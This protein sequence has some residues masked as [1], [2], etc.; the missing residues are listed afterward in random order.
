M[1]MQFRDGWDNHMAVYANTLFNIHCSKCKNVDCW[2]PYPEKVVGEKKHK[3][4][5]QITV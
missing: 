3:K 2:G 5:K 1:M 4:E